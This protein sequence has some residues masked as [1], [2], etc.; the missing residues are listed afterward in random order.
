MSYL[1]K[2]PLVM[3][4][5]SVKSSHFESELRHDFFNT[6][7]EREDLEAVEL[8]PKSNMSPARIPI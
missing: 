1:R 4:A 3:N 7:P 6:L 2:P 5:Q 8:E